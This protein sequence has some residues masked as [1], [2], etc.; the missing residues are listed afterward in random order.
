MTLPLEDK[1]GQMLLVG[2]YGLEAPDYILD[3]LR[4]GRIGGVILFGRNVESP[5]Q[6]ARMT[7]Q[8][9]DAAKYPALVAIDQE[10]GTVARLREGFTESPGAM[11]LS[12]GG[13]EKLAERMAQVLGTEMRALG[14]NWTYAPAVDI[15]YNID[16]PTVGTRS[17]GNDKEQVASMT[18]AVVRGFQAGGVAATAKHFPGLG[19]TAID[20]HQALAV[21]DTSVEQVIINDLIPYRAAMQA[22]LASIMTTHTKFTALDKDYPATLSPVI[23]KR[24]I[25]EELGFDGVVCTDCMEMKA[26]SN[27]YGSGESAV[28]AALAGIDLI[29]FSH[30]RTMQEAAYDALIEAAHSGRIPLEMIDCANKRIQQLKEQ[31]ATTQIDIGQIRASDH[32]ETADKAAHAGTVLLKAD[33]SV[34]PLNPDKHTIALI[35]FASF[36]DSEAVEAGGQTGLAKLVAEALPQVETIS[37]KVA[38]TDE[39]MLQKAQ[40]LAAESDVLVLATRN[41]HLWESEL[42]MAEDFISRAQQVILLCLRNPYDASV[43]EAGTVVCT[44]G[45]AAPSLQAAVDALLGEFTPSGKLPVNL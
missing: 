20:T 30:T 18:V 2:F 3:W 11:A 27:H 37:L 13:N 10:G 25:R 45:D 9:H 17:F 38:D 19:N 22:G 44:L 12:A 40:K 32:L 31:Y 34:F 28:L 8:I 5:E 6:V 21:L 33:A 41:A 29:L 15:S 35:E 4:E 26:I 23:V 7:Q 43:L 24:L 39:K 42:A 1:I 14:I 36:L 16:N